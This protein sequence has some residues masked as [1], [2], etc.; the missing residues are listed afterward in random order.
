MDHTLTMPKYICGHAMAMT[1]VVLLHTGIAAWAMMPEPPIVTPQQQV[2]QVS[3]VAPTVIQKKSVPVE[4]AI[5]KKQVV[6]TPPKPKGMIKVEP[7]TTPIVEK[8]EPKKQ[9]KPKQ[10]V[11]Q[12]AQTQLT[13]GLQSSTATEKTS[14]ITEP[15]AANYLKNPPPKYPRYARKR[16]QEGKVLL[17]VSVKT[18]GYPRNIVIAQSS[19]FD[20]LDNAALS[21]VKR[22]KFLPARNGS[23]KVEAN[24]K[25]PIEFRIN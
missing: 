18:D 10:V 22:W 6:K 14:A 25:V 5:V 11:M 16:K 9:E 4:A 17:D 24:V 13:S 19:G 8:E 12:Q 15:V 7:E 2:I 1:G 23:A 20:I 21:A 3:M